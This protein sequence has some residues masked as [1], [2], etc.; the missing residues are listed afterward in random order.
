MFV[1]WKIIEMENGLIRPRT[2]Y[3]TLNMP[4]SKALVIKH[5]IDMLLRAF[6]LCL[7]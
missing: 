1:K 3:L 2:G 4:E 6:D 7:E 5:E